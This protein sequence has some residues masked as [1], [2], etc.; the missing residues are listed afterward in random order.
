MR[1]KATQSKG[2]ALVFFRF[3][4]HHAWRDYCQIVVSKTTINLIIPPYLAEVD[5]V[6]EIP[7]N[8]CIRSGHAR[9]GYVGGI[10]RP[11]WTNN[12]GLQIRV[13]Q[14]H[15]LRCYGHN[16][17]RR[18]RQSGQHAL[19]RGRS[20]LEFFDDHRTEQYSYMIQPGKFYEPQ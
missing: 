18:F 12:A 1:L 9:G 14:A 13:A 15:N 16:L 20:F 5:D 3:M 17:D 2:F 4:C 8:D 19:N 6:L 7:R 11:S 10:V